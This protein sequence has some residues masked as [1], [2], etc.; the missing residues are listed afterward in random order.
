[1]LLHQELEH[2][3]M[4]GG[5]NGRTRP[6]GCN[7]VQP[8]RHVNCVVQQATVPFVSPPFHLPT[9]ST[10]SRAKTCANKLPTVLPAPGVPAVSQGLCQL[11]A[12]QAAV[13]LTADFADC[14]RCAGC[15]TGPASTASCANNCANDCVNRQP[16][17]TG[18]SHPTILP[19][20][21]QLKLKVL[22]SALG[23]SQVC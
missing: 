17:I 19:P 2:A 20:A 3:C 16:C 9:V 14:F 12:M 18:P 7:S 11:P 22:L 10:A 5:A 21:A 23:W 4:R 6:G 15:V 1:M 13:S 8:S